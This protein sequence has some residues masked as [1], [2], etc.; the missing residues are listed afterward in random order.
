MAEKELDQDVGCGD[1]EA[2]EAA[3]AGGPAETKRGRVRR[4]LID[5][6]VRD[7]MRFRRDVDEAAQ[8]RF[9]DRIAD[10]V[11]YMSDR[12]LAALRVWVGSHGEGSARAFWP[13]VVT[14]ISTAEAF[15][16]RPLEELPALVR[17]FASAAG[18]EALLA[19]RLVAEYEFWRRFK[20]PPAQSN[21][22]QRVSERAAE[23]SARAERIEDRMA[24]G[25]TPLHDDG[26]WL[27]WYRRTEDKARAL[28]AEPVS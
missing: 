5:P 6:L 11:A 1:R 21:D 22:R 15:E 9:L 10:D 25:L 7:G 16:P 8:G 12:G 17:W 28:L 27:S 2:G 20:R 26:A 24:R 3:Q 4:I 19:D 13:G 23:W 14:I 18:S